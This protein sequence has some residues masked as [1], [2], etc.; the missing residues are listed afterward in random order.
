MRSDILTL[1]RNALRLGLCGE[2]KAK[3][4]A[5]GDKKGL[6]EIALDSNGVE[7]VCQMADRG[8]LTKETVLSDFGEYIN[9]RFVRNKDGYTS[10]IYAY[11][12]GTVVMRTTLLVIMGGR[13]D[14]IVPR[15]RLGNI[16]TCCNAKVRVAGEGRA[17]VMD[18]KRGR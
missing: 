18:T 6:M 4:D 10:E 16:Y 1:K 9:G 15:N 11:Y 14:V 7:W 8:V 12:N 2:Y 3:W 5:A 17:E 13:V